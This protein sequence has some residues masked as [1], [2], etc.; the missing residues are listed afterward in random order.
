MLPVC[1]RYCRLCAR[2]KSSEPSH[3]PTGCHPP[4]MTTARAMKPRPE[5]MSR[6][7]MWISPMDMYAPPMAASTPQR[8]TQMYCVR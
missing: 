6:L 2:P 1:R 8:M 4:K 7:N 3:A 5:T